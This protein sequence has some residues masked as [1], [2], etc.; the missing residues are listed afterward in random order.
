MAK[1]AMVSHEMD[2]ETGK[3]K[4]VPVNEDSKKTSKPKKKK[5]TPPH[6]QAAIDLRRDMVASLVA[7]GMRQTEITKQLA[8]KTIMRREKDGLKEYPNPSYMEN[9]ETGLPYDKSQINRDVAELRKQWRKSA[10]VDSTEWFARQLAE[11]DEIKRKF[12]AKEDVWGVARAVELEIK[13]TGTAKPQKLQHSWDDA[14][15]GKVDKMADLF[16]LMREREAENKS[17]SD[18]P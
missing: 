1:K 16:K 9:P 13:L 5:E 2:P 15:L 11:I 18:K 6:I 10:E 3:L 17:G 8:T 14:Q 4:E 7:R 12:W